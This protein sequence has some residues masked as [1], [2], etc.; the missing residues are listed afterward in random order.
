MPFSLLKRNLSILFILQAAH[1]FLLAIP[2]IVLFYQVNGL[3][4]SQVFILQSVFAVS[5]LIIEIPSGYFAD[6]YGRKISLVIGSLLTALGF[7]FYAFAASFW[8]F[9]FGEIILA[10]ANGLISGADS[11][12]LYD[13]LATEKKEK[14]YALYEG[15]YISLGN[16]SEGLAGITGGVLAFYWLRLPFTVQAILTTAVIPLTFFLKEPPRKNLVVASTRARFKNLWHIIKIALWKNPRQRWG[17]LLAAAFGASTLHIVWLIQPYFKEVDLPLYWYGLLWA[18]LQF[19]AG[20]F[21]WHAWRLYRYFPQQKVFLFLPLLLAASYILPATHKHIFFVAFFFLAYAVRGIHSPL[22][23]EK[24]QKLSSSQDRA[25][26]LSLKS[27]LVRLIFAVS[28]PL[29]GIVADTSLSLALALSGIFFAL[30]LLF[31]GY[32]ATRVNVFSD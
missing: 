22:L 6:L 27:M 20:F 5:V 23:R 4:L 10:L 8:F 21:A 29:A 7:T 3:S 31:F 18:L 1:W 13:S 11:A 9:F 24:I 25:T 28:G 17:I 15:R 2:T 14:L 12:L 16:F 30:L 19:V 26:V 32:M